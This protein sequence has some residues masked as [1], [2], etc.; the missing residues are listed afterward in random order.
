MEN[1]NIAFE[2]KRKGVWDNDLHL[3]TRFTRVSTWVQ[4]YIWRFFCTAWKNISIFYIGRDLI[5]SKSESAPVISACSSF[6]KADFQSSH[7][8]E[9]TIMIVSMKNLK[10]RIVFL[11][12]IKLHILVNIAFVI[13][14]G[15]LGHGFCRLHHKS[16]YYTDRQGMCLKN[17]TIGHSTIGFCTIPWPIPCLLASQHITQESKPRKKFILHKWHVG[18]PEADLYAQ[19][20]INHSTL[21]HLTL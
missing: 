4:N 8:W 6:L 5:I 13:F 11:L 14:K 21:I 10:S 20:K 1:A 7:L 9:G 3:S 15:S 12:V 16:N 2:K 18:N 17:N 19:T